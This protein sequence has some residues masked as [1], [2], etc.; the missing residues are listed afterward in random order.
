M[1]EKEKG[2][3]NGKEELNGT[4]IKKSMQFMTMNQ[5]NTFAY[6]ICAENKQSNAN[7]QCNF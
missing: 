4:Q 3:G 1:R 2:N 6:E 5:R 7:F